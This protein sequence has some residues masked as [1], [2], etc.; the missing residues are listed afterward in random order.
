M[1]KQ[2]NHAFAFFLQDS[3]QAL[4]KSAE[5]EKKELEQSSVFFVRKRKNKHFKGNKLDCFFLFWNAC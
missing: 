1:T 4:K 3:T 5:R 2:R